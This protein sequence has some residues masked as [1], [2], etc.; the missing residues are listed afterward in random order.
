MPS[1]KTEKQAK[2]HPITAVKRHQALD[3]L[4][5][6]ELDRLA[7]WVHDGW[8]QEKADAGFHF[9]ADAHAGWAPG[10]LPLPCEKCHRDMIKFADLPVDKQQFDVTTIGTTIAGLL[11]MGF[12]IVALKR[13]NEA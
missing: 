5:K 3:L 4:S 13:K 1:R 10:S 6:S 7:E 2:P 12:Q 8:W 11:E 9:P